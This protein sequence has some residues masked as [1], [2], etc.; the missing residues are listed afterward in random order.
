MYNIFS[1]HLLQA[2]HF[3]GNRW[4]ANLI[5]MAPTLQELKAG[6]AETYLEPVNRK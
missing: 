4:Y 3:A 1:K 5:E 6:W 2:E